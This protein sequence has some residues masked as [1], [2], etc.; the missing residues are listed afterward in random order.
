MGGRFRKGTMASAHLDA[1]YFS[2]SLYAIGA[3]QAATPVLELR[4]S[5]SEN[6]SLCVGFLRGTA[7]GSSSLFQQLNSHWF[8]KPE[9][10][11]TYLPALEHC[12]GGPGVGL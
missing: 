6:V 5:E 9:V 8:L 1:R 7:W 3:F 10:V 12:A 2:S 11:G 4:G